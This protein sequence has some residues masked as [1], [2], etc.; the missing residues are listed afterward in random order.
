MEFVKVKVSLDVAGTYPCKWS[1]CLEFLWGEGSLWQYRNSEA[2]SSR[3]NKIVMTCVCSSAGFPNVT[4]A[5]DSSQ[6]HTG[7]NQDPVTQSI[8]N[9]SIIEPQVVHCTHN[10]VPMLKWSSAWYRHLGKHCKSLNVSHCPVSYKETVE[11]ET[12]KDWERWARENIEHP[13]R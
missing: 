9:E 13:R 7:I 8:L 11:K 12:N 4:R 10:Q 1:C 5:P 6:S 2:S 3:R